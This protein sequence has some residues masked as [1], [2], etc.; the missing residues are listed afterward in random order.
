MNRHAPEAKFSFDAIGLGTG[1]IQP[2]AQ[3]LPGLLAVTR[4]GLDECA[5]VVSN[6][7]ISGVED[8]PGATAQFIRQW[9]GCKAG[10]EYHG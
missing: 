10:R 2:E 1:G 3:A 5:V 7:P 8:N 4:I 9:Q 6:T